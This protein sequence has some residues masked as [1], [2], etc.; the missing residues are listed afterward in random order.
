[1]AMLT[2]NPGG[3]ERTEKEFEALARGAGFAAS[4]QQWN[5]GGTVETH[6]HLVEHSHYLID[7]SDDRNLKLLKK[8][9]NALPESGKRYS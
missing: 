2:L 4:K 6:Q 7:R 8:C 1:M 3:K 5:W 9:W